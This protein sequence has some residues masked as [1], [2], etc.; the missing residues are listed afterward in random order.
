MTSTSG[1][2][3]TSEDG[4]L[5]DSVHLIQVPTF[6]DARGRLAPFEFNQLPFVPLRMFV[7]RDVPVGTTRGGHAHRSQRHLLIC[8]AGKV[9]GTCASRAIIGRSSL[10]SPRRGS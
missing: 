1:R 8:L 6:D 7:V 2:P 9:V 10:T 5:S 4:S 3:A